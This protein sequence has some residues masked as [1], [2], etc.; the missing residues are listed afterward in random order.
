[1]ALP[2]LIY[3]DFFNWEACWQAPGCST[4]YELIDHDNNWMVEVP[5][6]L[7]AVQFLDKLHVQIS[8]TKRS[9]H[10]CVTQN[11]WW[12]QQV[13]FASLQTPLWSL[14]HFLR[15]PSS[16][17]LATWW[18]EGE[19]KEG[20]WDREKGKEWRTE[21]LWARINNVLDGSTLLK[22]YLNHVQIVI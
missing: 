3:V 22:A 16:I 20:M 4:K 9:C 2:I 7:L 5:N 15:P 17:L 10:L 1:M 18:W 21:G 13:F 14:R 6:P 8:P 19:R 12:I 11:E